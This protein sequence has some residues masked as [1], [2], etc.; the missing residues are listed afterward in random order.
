MSE[1]KSRIP[2]EIELEE[3]K[4]LDTSRR[5]LLIGGAAAIAGVATLAGDP[6]KAKAAVGKSGI[7]YD[8]GGQLERLN[9][10]NYAAT[11]ELVDDL[12]KIAIATW[13]GITVKGVKIGPSEVESKLRSSNVD[14]VRSMMQN[15]VDQTGNSREFYLDKPKFIT[16]SQYEE[17]YEKDY[18]DEAVFV[19][20]PSPSGPSK[21]K[22]KTG[23]SVRAQMAAVPFGM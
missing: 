14:D 12:V 1:K 3:S 9:D 20:L 17:G 22:G 6:K 2:N 10:V 4:G 7:W 19:L 13:N 8:Y 18:M 21:S 16:M 23:G 11:P 15:I 5:G